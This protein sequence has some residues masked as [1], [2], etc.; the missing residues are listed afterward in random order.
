MPTYAKASVG[1]GGEGGCERVIR[2]TFA[3]DPNFCRILEFYCPGCGRQVE[4]EYLP[5][6]H[7]LT[8]DTSLPRQMRQR[9]QTSGMV[10]ASATLTGDD[11]VDG[12]KAFYILI[13]ARPGRE[14]DVVQ[15]LRDIR[16]CVEDEPAT[17]PWYA[18]RHSTTTFRLRQPICARARSEPALDHPAI[19]TISSARSEDGPSP[20]PW[21]VTGAGLV[22]TSAIVAMTAR[23]E[24]GQRVAT[25]GAVLGGINFAL[26]Y[27]AFVRR[28]PRVA[29][30]DEEFRLY[31]ALLAVGA[32]VLIAE[33]WT[34]DVLPGMEAI[35]AATFTA[36]CFELL[37]FGF[38]QY[39]QR[40]DYGSAYGTAA[41][42]IVLFLW[43]YYASIIF[44]IMDVPERGN[45]EIK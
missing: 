1:E 41:T 37:K 31:L 33:V 18:V 24:H 5:P 22:A 32:I 36:V 29:A 21:L 27:R 7:P 3:P 30:R 8:Q 23:T 43:I 26:M 39:A 14:D 9:G 38:S 13:E 20:A 35:R 34:E 25:A 6:G 16:A 11:G 44:I 42:A 2:F 19:D 17:G 40:A 28:Q 10:T 45:P 12:P 4:S 15:M